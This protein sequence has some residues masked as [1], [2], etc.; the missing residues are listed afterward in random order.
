MCASGAD[1]CF[2]SRRRRTTGSTCTGGASS[3]RPGTGWQHTS[4]S[5]RAGEAGAAPLSLEEARERIEAVEPGF[6]ASQ[7][8]NAQFVREQVLGAPPRAPT[9][10]TASKA[11]AAEKAAAY[12]KAKQAAS[13][14]PVSAA[15]AAKLQDAQAAL[16][17]R[18]GAGG[19]AKAAAA[20]KYL[21]MRRKQQAAEAYLE[22]K[23]KGEQGNIEQP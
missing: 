18:K 10:A 20:A 7:D 23:E 22:E 12:L 2:E 3:T 11:S 14:Q 15:A 6:Q 13:G 21:E 8:K 19:G 16:L 5:M 17:A 1:A 9:T 4:D